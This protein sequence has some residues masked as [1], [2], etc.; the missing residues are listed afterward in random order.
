[1]K[2]YDTLFIDLL[3]VD[4]MFKQSYD[5]YYSYLKREIFKLKF[6]DIEVPQG[7]CIIKDK[8]YITCYIICDRFTYRMHY[9]VLCWLLWWGYLNR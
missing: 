4:I 9:F 7:L 5:E 2:K 8:V 6:N 3:E 1:M